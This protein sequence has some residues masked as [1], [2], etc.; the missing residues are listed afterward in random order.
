MSLESCTSPDDLLRFMGNLAQDDVYGPSQF[1]SSTPSIYDSAW[2]STVYKNQNSEQGWMFPRRFQYVLS[3]QQPDVDGILSTAASLLALLNRR[4]RTLRGN[5]QG[6]ISQRIECAI[7]CL[8]NLLQGWDAAESNQVGFELIVPSTLCRIARYGVH[9]SFPGRKSLDMIHAKKMQKFHPQMLYSDLQTTMLHSL[10]AF[11]G[12]VD[13][14]LLKHHC[15]VENRVMASPAATSA[16]LMYVKEWDPRAETYLNRLV[17]CSGDSAGGV[18]AAFPTCNFELSWALSTLFLHVGLP[19]EEQISHLRPLRVFLKTITSQ[20][21][22]LIGWAPGILPDADDTA[23]VLMTINFLGDQVDFSPMVTSFRSHPCFK[24]YEMERNPSLSAN[25]NVL[26]AL[27]TSE[28]PAAYIED[29][30]IVLDYLLKLWKEGDLSD[31]WNISSHYSCMILSSAL[32]T[33]LQLY[34]DSQLEGFSSTS[35]VRDIVLCLVQMLSRMLSQQGQEGSW[36]NSLEVTSYCALTLSQLLRLPFNQEFQDSQLRPALLRAQEYVKAHWNDPM[37]SDHHDYLWVEKVSYSSGLLRKVY[38]VAALNAKVDPLS[39]S[40]DLSQYFTVSNDFDRIKTLLQSIPMFQT[41]TMVSWHLTLLEAALWTR[42]LQE[43]KHDIYLPVEGQNT[44]DKHMSLIPVIWTAC[45][46]IGNHVLS[47]NTIWELIFI[48]LLGYQ[49]DEFME[50][51]TTG[52][53]KPALEELKQHLEYECKFTANAKAENQASLPK[54]TNCNHESYQSPPTSI[55][56]VPPVLAEAEASIIQRLRIYIN[57]LLGHPKVLE[58]SQLMQ[59]DFASEIYHYLSGHIAHVASNAELSL[60]HC[61]INPDYPRWVGSVGADDTSCP[62]ATLFFVCVIS[63]ST[64]T[65]FE[66]SPLERY[67]SRSVIRHLAIMCRQYNDYGSVARDIDEDNLNS[68]HFPEFLSSN[69]EG[70]TMCV[71]GHGQVD[72]PSS[73][74]KEQLLAIAEF[75]REQMELA[76]QRLEEASVEKRAL[77]SLRVYMNGTDLWGLIYLHRD[78][79][80]RLKHHPSN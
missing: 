78:Y 37:K 66:G 9:F 51:S 30:E 11:V 3:L 57:W 6:D 65:A 52:L 56:I 5:D 62:L 79:S 41:P 31:K 24:T 38:A 26:L 64:K 63:D 49:T 20:Q 80:N 7:K 28:S 72:Y 12:V 71:D 2:M 48:S 55:G 45:N 19:S 47:P 53:S 21:S 58:S 16:Y 23:R 27:I 15:T 33:V 25:C 42:Y 13:F 35:M 61:T 10:E 29:I 36:D 67:L 54:Q 22:G 40:A 34:I 50:T 69:S 74:M 75:E 43:S 59:R 32:V 73:S 4:E 76:F 44:K 70:K 18:P 68:L 1:G 14:D 39:F 77:A 8:Q 46:S 17:S 60:T